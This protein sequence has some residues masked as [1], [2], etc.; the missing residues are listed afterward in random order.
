MTSASYQPGGLIAGDHPQLHR[1]VT[2]AS[3][4]DLLRGAVL[5]EILLGAASSAAKAGGNTGN[6]T[7]TLDASTPVLAG[8][9]AGV[10]TVRC[11]AAASNSGTFEVQDPDGYVLGDVVVGATFSDDVKFVIADGSSDFIVG[12][13]FDITVAAGSGKFVLSLAAARDG[14]Q[15]PA[16]VLA[17][18]ADASDG[19]LTVPV[20]TSGEFAADKLVFGTGHT[21]SSVEAAWRR[22]G[23][24]MAIRTRV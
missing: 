23:R 9:K 6:G 20:F 11:T 15:T 21:S 19:D 22:A 18:D 5:G 24:P 13:G 10:Y 7:L 17:E 12:D 2:L 8:A 1:N 4:Q 14:S 16:A 3:G